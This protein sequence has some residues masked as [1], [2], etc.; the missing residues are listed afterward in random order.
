MSTYFPIIYL[1]IWKTF[2]KAWYTDLPTSVI[3]TV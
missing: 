1:K 3:V 2:E